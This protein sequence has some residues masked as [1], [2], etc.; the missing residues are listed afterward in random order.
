MKGEIKMR[1]VKI[2]ILALYCLLF[3]MAA[4][5]DIEFGTKWGFID[6]ANSA[7]ALFAVILSWILIGSCALIPASAG[8]VSV[9][10]L[11]AASL[12]ALVRALEE[13]EDDTP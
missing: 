10:T 3:S 5:K 8:N 9:T 1:S 13:Q 7:V 11:D 2:G 12:K 4:F 6:Y